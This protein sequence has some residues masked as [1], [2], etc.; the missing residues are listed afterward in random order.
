[1]ALAAAVVALAGIKSAMV[2]P[3]FDPRVGAVETLLHLL[4]CP[5]CAAGRSAIAC[6]RRPRCTVQAKMPCSSDTAKEL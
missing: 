5:S 6:G 3:L 2:E 1:V 4:W